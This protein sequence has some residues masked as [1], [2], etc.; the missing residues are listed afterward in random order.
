[1]IILSHQFIVV[2]KYSDL[3]HATSVLISSVGLKLM[4]TPWKLASPKLEHNLELHY[5]RSK[6]EG[7]EAD[8]MMGSYNVE[9]SC[10]GEK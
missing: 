6:Y 2:N 4:V 8:S 10:C 1:M 7:E 3:L 5:T 9:C